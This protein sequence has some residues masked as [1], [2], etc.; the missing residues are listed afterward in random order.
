MERAM[1]DGRRERSELLDVG[2]G[3]QLESGRRSPITWRL[4]NPPDV[5]RR[6]ELEPDPPRLHRRRFYGGR[7]HDLSNGDGHTRQAI[8]AYPSEARERARRQDLAAVAA[9]LHKL[10]SLDEAKGGLETHHVDHQRERYALA[11]PPFYAINREFSL[12]H[13]DSHS[14]GLQN[15]RIRWITACRS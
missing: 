8:E 13:G 9:D 15:R 1:K 4:G 5:P 3:R 7:A 11:A 14:A 2:E 10:A 12:G 6:I